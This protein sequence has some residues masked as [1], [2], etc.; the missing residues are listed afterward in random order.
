VLAPFALSELARP[1]YEQRAYQELA[2]LLEPVPVEDLRAYPQFGFWLADAWR[3]LGKTKAALELTQ[4][5]AA[6]ARMSCIERLEYDRLNLE[7]MLRF[8][9]GDIAGAEQVWS[10]LLARASTS[11]STEFIARA[12]NNL[13]II[14][15]LQVRPFEAVTCYQR[16][17][18]AYRL[19][20]LR[21]G[22]AQSHQNLA[23]TYRELGHMD[24]ADEHFQTAQRYA[25]ED[26]SM[27]EMARAENERALLIYLA[28]RD[29]PL[30]RAT[31]QRALRR[32]AALN[33]PREFGD[34]LRVLA[35]IELGAGDLLAAR[36]HAEHA[37]EH[38]RATG[39][40]LLEAEVIEVI[41]G[42]DSIAGNEDAAREAHS[43]AE[44]IFLS[45]NAPAWGASFRT[46]VQ[47]LSKQSH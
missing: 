23:I 7:G 18:T 39:H 16:A 31:A 33:D 15:T 12:N 46:R 24:E 22:I 30:A 35:M 32:F 37:L 47:A 38:A 5:I 6:A 9:T 1:L 3:R 43:H 19:L 42:V 20:G 11:D 27:D 36:A 29:A 14:C 10:D 28:R 44:E 25:Q 34:T 8:E 13:G 41:A 17:V 2:D 21:R 45:V 4:S 26:G 40:R